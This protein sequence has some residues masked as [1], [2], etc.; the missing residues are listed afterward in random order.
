[1]NK[2]TETYKGIFSIFGTQ[3]WLLKDIQTV[4]FNYSTVTTDTYIR[5][6]IIA[7]GEGINLSSTSGQ[8]IIEIYTP[9]GQ[10]PLG[11]AVIADS[12]DQFLV[13]KTVDCP[14]GGRVQF[15]KSGISIRGLDTAN[16]ALYK[17]MYV[18]PFSFYGV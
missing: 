9:A 6:N 16:P 7:S 12:L 11:S 3:E 18:I 1:M 8:V 2:Y 17:T 13:G 15:L 5:V 4:P 10:G 14:L